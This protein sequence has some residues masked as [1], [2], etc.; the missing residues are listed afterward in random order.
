MTTASQQYCSTCGAPVSAQKCAICGG[1]VTELALEDGNIT[2]N[3]L[4]T[5]VTNPDLEWAFEAWTRGEHARMISHVLTV[6]GAQSVRSLTEPQGPI[7]AAIYRGFSLFLAVNKAA[8]QLTVEVPVARFPAT[9]YVGAMR[10][11]LELSDE[12]RSPARYGARGDLLMMRYVGR[13]GAMNPEV[14]QIALDRIVARATEESKLFATSVQARPLTGEDHAS[15]DFSSLPKPNA[16]SFAPP[17]PPPPAPAP[18]PKPG[19]KPPPPPLAPTPAVPIPAVIAQARPSGM[20]DTVQ[21]ILGPDSSKKSQPPTLPT[22]PPPKSAKPSAAPLPPAPLTQASPVQINVDNGTLSSLLHKAQ[23]LGAMLSFADQP[24]SMALLIR[25]TVYRAILENESGAPDAV[26]F[27]FNETLALTKEIY[28]TAPGKRRGAMAIPEAQPAFDVMSR[29]V[30]AREQVKPS[31]PA[32][33]T[34]ITTS[35][36]A[37]QHLARYVSEIDQTPSDLELR[38]FLALGA[39]AELLVRTKLPAPTQ[40]RLRGILEHSRAEGA[41]QKNV[42]LMMTALNRMIA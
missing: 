42:D 17:P 6:A 5:G 33:M 35:Q 9:Q 28:I 27:L 24:A 38:H 23:T 34:P 41:Q 10:L 8:D 19:L 25:A 40:E 3:V 15:M 16:L 21:P 7:F 20:F 11:A 1:E 14:L 30:E 22:H 12:P 18:L 29:I 2:E 39:L 4:L 37:K 13:L 26:A 36:D 32:Q 31:G